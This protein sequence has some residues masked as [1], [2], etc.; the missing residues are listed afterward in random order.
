M[1]KYTV[2]EV[3][4]I[5]EISIR[6]LHYYDHI[7]LLIP[8]KRSAAG[9]RF[10]TENELLTL[11][12]ILFYKELDFSLSEIKL[13]LAGQNFDLIGALKEQ[14]QAL[15]QR[16]QRLDSILD[17][18]EKTIRHLEKKDCMKSPDELYKGFNKEKP[19]IYR[20]EAIK[21]YGQ[22]TIEKSERNLMALGK[23]GYESL[24][25]KQKENSRKLFVLK[26]E[27]P[28]SAE[29]QKEIAEHFQIIKQLWGGDK[30]DTEMSKAYAGLGQL[31][32]ADD[33]YTMIDGEPQVEFASFLN[34]AMRHFATTQLT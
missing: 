28:T 8:D 13:I 34:R 2:K 22:E 5:S 20:K 17:T 30:T 11:Q 14:K 4:K 25:R 10:Y 6:T 32:E 1:K 27:D 33:R 7:G 26:N 24:L 21:K 29:V 19:M 12:Q 31:Y 18:I 9:Y 23:E 16:K 15:N 3:A